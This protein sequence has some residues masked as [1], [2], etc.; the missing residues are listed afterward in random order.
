MRQIYHIF[1]L[2][3]VSSLPLPASTVDKALSDTTTDVI[4]EYGDTPAHL[5]HPKGKGA[6][7]EAAPGE[8]LLR[9]DWLGRYYVE[10][11]RRITITPNADANEQWILVFLMGSAMGAL[12]HQRNYLVLHAGAIRAKDSAVIFMGP[13]GIGKSTLAAGFHQRGYPFLADDVCAVAMV[14]G[15]PCVIPGFLQLKLWEDILKKLGKDKDQL[16]SLVWSRNLEKYFMPVMCGNEN[17][18]ALETVFN[19]GAA[20][21]DHISLLAIS[22]AAKID[23]I[24][25]NT[26]RRGFLHGLGNKQ[27][28]FQNCARVAMQTNVF[29]VRRPENIFLL[30]EL[31]DQLEEIFH[32]CVASSE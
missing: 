31:L 1:G 20:N 5:T 8:F 26:Y 27:K 11:G 3:I 2:N 24:F 14:N 7:Y 13:S 10:D 17:P 15:K 23:P 29:Q 25:R 32:G 18:V 16:K 30:D 6:I 28:H 9:I 12:L 22:G 19:L 4:I 21:V